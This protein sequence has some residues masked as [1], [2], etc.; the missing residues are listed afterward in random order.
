MTSTEGVVELECMWSKDGSWWTVKPSKCAVKRRRTG[1]ILEVVFE[2]DSKDAI[3]YAELEDRLRM[4]GRQVQDN[5]C[6]LLQP[7][8][9]VIALHEGGE[10]AKYMDATVVSARRPL[11]PHGHGEGE[12]RCTFTIKWKPMP[13]IPSLSLEAKPPTGTVDVG[14]DKLCFKQPATGF[15]NH[16]YIKRWRQ[17][18]E[19]MLHMPKQS[20]SSSSRHQQSSSVPFGP[21]SQEAATALAGLNAGQDRLGML[22]E[23]AHGAVGHGVAG[24]VLSPA[25]STQPPAPHTLKDHST[26]QGHDKHSHH[27]AQAAVPGQASLPVS[28]HTPAPS[29]E[30]PHCP[31]TPPSQPPPPQ[32]LN[33]ATTDE[34]PSAPSPTRSGASLEEIQ[35]DK[36]QQQQQQHWGHQWQQQRHPMHS[37][38]TAPSQPRAK[39][40]RNPYRGCSPRRHGHEDDL[41]SA[42][43]LQCEQ[44]PRQ[45]DEEVDCQRKL[46]HATAI[47]MGAAHRQMANNLLRNVRQDFADFQLQVPLLSICVDDILQ[48]ALAQSLGQINLSQST[49]ESFRMAISA[50]GASTLDGKLG[51]MLQEAMMMCSR[52]PQK[53]TPPPAG[54]ARGE[55]LRSAPVAVPPAARATAPFVVPAVNAT[56][57]VVAPAVTAIAPVAAPAVTAQM[58]TLGTGGTHQRPMITS[59]GPLLHYMHNATSGPRKR[60][61]LSDDACVRKA[62]RT[63]ADAQGPSSGGIAQ[64]QQGLSSGGVAQQKQGPQPGRQQQ[65]Q[66]QEQ[67]QGE[68]QH[69]CLN[70]QDGHLHGSPRIRSN[71]FSFSK[72]GPS[73]PLSTSL[74]SLTPSFLR[75]DPR[76]EGTPAEE[77][78]VREH[79]STGPVARP[80]PPLQQP[81]S[82]AAPSPR[83]RRSWSLSPFSS[84]SNTIVPADGDHVRDSEVGHH[85]LLARGDHERGTNSGDHVAPA[86]E[87]HGRGP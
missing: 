9:E 43:P 69:H 65:Q 36:G 53:P 79:Q 77:G 11:W 8:T 45:L 81:S 66:Q 55:G 35:S 24:R 83:L 62:P 82:H 60:S 40:T 3:A 4:A 71:R 38:P 1:P 10:E 47:L 17:Q 75:R 15:Y 68:Q 72:S 20:G 26:A 70:A 25:A 42:P 34:A 39:D 61:A 87:D 84:C 22:L 41:S 32:P 80:Q 18:M 28:H 49:I 74:F 50:T 19:Q 46:Q 21:E 73:S 13:V 76:K 63:A 59:S 37:G 57:P 78:V 51:R 6:G 85:V 23:A 67:E 14:I 29:E 31:P 33:L 12:C 58:S 54:P 44:P 27:G 86:N 64:Q 2:D 7:G 5:E 30:T 48:I 56:A 16:P 52:A